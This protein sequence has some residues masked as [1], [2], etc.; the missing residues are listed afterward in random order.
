M[1]TTGTRTSTG[2]VQ[3]TPPV[4]GAGGLVGF[5]G[6]GGLQLFDLT[7]LQPVVTLAP[8][9]VLQGEPVAYA[10]SG[11]GSLL[12]SG[13]FGVSDATAVLTFRDLEAGG[14]VRQL[15]L[16]AGG[17]VSGQDWVRLVGDDPPDELA[18][19]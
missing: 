13:Y 15:C 8:A 9:P 3:R 6:R 18:C 7:T 12:L 14:I 11:D 1:T 2:S 5:P 16:D 10:F 17:S 19:R 4:V